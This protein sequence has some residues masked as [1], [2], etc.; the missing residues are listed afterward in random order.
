MVLRITCF[1]YLVLLTACASV[2][3]PSPLP[4][5][6]A[7][8][9]LQT[10]RSGSIEVSAGILTDDQAAAHFGIDL[11]AYDIQAIWLSITNGS[12]RKLWFLRN[13]LDADYYS[14]DE[15]AAIVGK[16]I[17]RKDFEVARQRLRDELIRAALE[18]H[19]VSQ[20]FVLAPK[21]LGGRYVDVRLGEDIYDVGLA[22][23][24]ARSRGEE[25]PQARV[26]EFRFG[27]AIPLP[28]GIF[29]YERL[30]PDRIYSTPRPDLDPDE[31]RAALEA[32]PCCAS[33]EEASD[34]GDPLNLVVVADTG[35][36]LNSLSRAGWSF[37]HRITARSVERLVGAT[38]QGDAYPV[39][40]VSNLYLFGR[41]Q[42]FA[43]QRARP[44]IAQRNHMRAWLA[45]FTFENK[46]VWIG[47]VSRDIGI[48]L[49]P[50]SPSLTTHIIDPEVDLTREYLLHSLLA[51][52][53]VDRFGFV[54]GSQAASREAPAL[55][56]ADDPYFSDGMRLV[57]V[58]SPNPIP[59]QQVR[60]FGWERSA[61]P[62]AEGQ[63]EAAGEH[64]K[65][66]LP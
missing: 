49:T 59:Y 36:A 19:T 42:D 38:L 51:D 18:P 46:N 63:S 47:Q 2:Y 28:D 40:P 5:P 48:K 64:T 16:Y 58:I 30:H 29:D 26:S 6:A 1:C 43:L 33:N 24:A 3:A 4:L 37:T 66:I 8:E 27:F 50:K 44:N 17:P 41:K 61:A 12:D 9:D 23:R 35:D 11:G 62:V 65:P 21:A 55:N 53:L 56:L 52:G 32:L 15:V 54:G 39:A 22:R 34:W 57:V 7:I 13:A 45:P 25:L 10:K 31:F 20:G 60:S 14:A